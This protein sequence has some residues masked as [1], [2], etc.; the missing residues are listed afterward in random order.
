MKNFL[1]LV[2]SENGG[3]NAY[4]MFRQPPESQHP[5]PHALLEGMISH[6]PCDGIPFTRIKAPSNDG[7]DVQILFAWA[8]FPKLYQYYST[9]TQSSDPRCRAT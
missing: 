6:N 5:L 9:K 8:V 3:D 1:P 7:M 4:T 2:A